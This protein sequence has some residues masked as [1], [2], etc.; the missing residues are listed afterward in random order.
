MHRYHALVE[1][2][3]ARGSA[4]ERLLSRVF[5]GSPELL[6]THLVSNR[7]LTEAQIQRLREVL[8]KHSREGG[9]RAPN[10]SCTRLR[11]PPGWAGP[12][13]RSSTPHAVG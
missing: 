5:G 10:G 3:H 9:K 8:R 7:D 1:R 6:L 11:Y 13:W 4:L 2:E 12:H